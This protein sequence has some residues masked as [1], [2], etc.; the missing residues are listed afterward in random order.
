MKKY[1][2]MGCLLLV[3]CLCSFNIGNAATYD[4]TNDFSAENN[5]NGAWSYG[6]SQSRGSDFQIDTTSAEDHT[7][8]FMKG[9]IAPDFQAATM[10]IGYA[11]TEINHP[12][13]NVPAGTVS[14][15]PG[16]YCQNTVIRWTAPSS[17]LYEIEGWFTGNDFAYPTTTDVA[18]LH[19]SGQIYSGTINSYRVPL[20]FSL[21][22]KMNAG[23]MLDFTVG[24]GDNGNYYGDS[25][26]INATVRDSILDVAIDIKPGGMPNCVNINEAGAIPVAILGSA[27]INVRDV[28]PATVFLENMPV[29]SSGKNRL[30]AH[31]EDVNTDGI[32]DLVLQIEDK[33]MLNKEISSATLTGNLYNSTPIKGTDSICIV[34]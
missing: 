34:P 33:G 21:S 32:E 6:W 13:V 2:G 26:G 16:P 11:V 18:I 19:G 10:H 5:P 29:K 24:C 9:W 20:Y 4:I 28:N 7:Y 8:G 23:E 15:H 12:T 3:L 27:G 31:Y 22:E 25:T 17:G 30:L 14:F 1:V